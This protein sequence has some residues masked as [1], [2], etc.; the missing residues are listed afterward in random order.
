MAKPLYRLCE[1]QQKLVWSEDCDKAFEL[2]KNKLVEAPVLAHPDFSQPFILDTDASDVAIGAVLSQKLDGREYVVA[3]ASRTLTKS[4]RKYC[5]TK[6]ELLALVHFVKYFRHY[7][8]GKTFTVRTDHSSLKW[9]MRFKNPEGQLARWLE[10]LSSYSMKIEHRPGRL[11]GNADGMS[12]I[13]C[14]Q[15]GRTGENSRS[16]DDL[17]VINQL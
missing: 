1:K 14:R 11:H 13:P 16:S 4:E 15:C 6:R 17:L 12:R 5:I 7:L 8:Y 3:Y 10:V 2:L 9:L